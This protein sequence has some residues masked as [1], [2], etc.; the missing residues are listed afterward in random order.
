CRKSL[1]VAIHRRAAGKYQSLQSASLQLLEKPLR[2]DDVVTGVAV[3]LVAPARPHA[4]LPGEVIDDIGAFQRGCEI[5]IDEVELLEGE[6]AV[7]PGHLQV[8]L[9]SSTPVIVG[10][11]IDAQH[12][13]A[14]GQKALG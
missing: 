10:E 13:V 14:V 11:G 6:V 4:W 7:V 5:G 8:L 2:G 3:E 1:S 12:L 9:L